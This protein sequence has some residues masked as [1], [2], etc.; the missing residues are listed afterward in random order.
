[1]LY[2]TLPVLAYEASVVHFHWLKP[3]TQWPELLEAAKSPTLI[4]CHGSELRVDPTLGDQER[5]RITT[6][7]R[8]ADLVHCVSNDLYR[9]ALELG[10]DSDRA[11]VQY[12]GADLDFFRP[13]PRPPTSG[14][15]RIVSVGRYHWVKGYTFALLGLLGALRRGIEA[16]YTIVASVLPTDE[17][18]I[19]TTVRDLDL[20]DRVHLTGPL[21]RAGVR[22]ELAKA[23]LFLLS[24]V[25]EGLSIS[26]LEAMAMQ[27]PV[28]ATDAG[29]TSEAVENEKEGLLVPCRD[30]EAITDAIVGLAKNPDLARQMGARARDRVERQFDQESSLDNWEEVYARL[31]RMC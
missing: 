24:S 16:T 5:H 9:H 21:D 2:Q 27:L 14:P 3:L 1:M 7:L 17:L 26:T 29:G 10:V 19:R 4:T 22:R 31:A 13:P 23:D 20:T 6:V 15:V 12:L 25:S 11:F 28:I 8:A 18:E 30:A